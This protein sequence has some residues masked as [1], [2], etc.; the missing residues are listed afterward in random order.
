MIQIE[1]G[2]N[3]ASGLLSQIEPEKSY[4]TC[5]LQVRKEPSWDK[6]MTYHSTT[7][8]IA[9]PEPNSAKSRAVITL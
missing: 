1:P 9:A 5:P 6:G 2:K 7:G 8:G 4:D 3:D